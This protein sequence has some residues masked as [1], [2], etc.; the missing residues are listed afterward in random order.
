MPAGDLLR[1][2]VTTDESLQIIVSYKPSAAYF[3]VS[4]LATPHEFIKPRP[5]YATH[6]HSARDLVCYRFHYKF[7]GHPRLPAVVPPGPNKH[8]SG[9]GGGLFEEIKI[10]R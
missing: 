2:A 7:R 8:F 1:Y 3:H 5:G 6:L 10:E 9:P 4:E